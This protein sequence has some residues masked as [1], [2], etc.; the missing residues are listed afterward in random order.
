[1][2]TISK[3]PAFKTFYYYYYYYLNT[4]VVKVSMQ[5]GSFHTNEYN[6]IGLKAHYWGNNMCVCVAGG[7]NFK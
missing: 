5:N 7:N 3:T 4:Q 2:W 6:I 1:M